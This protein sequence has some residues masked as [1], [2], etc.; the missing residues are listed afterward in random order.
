[1][2]PLNIHWRP[3]W[4][5]E[6]LAETLPPWTVKDSEWTKLKMVVR[7]PKFDRQEMS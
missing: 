5:W 6:I 4:F 2:D 3:M 7:F 1:M